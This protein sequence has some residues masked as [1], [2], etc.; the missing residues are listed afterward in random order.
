MLYRAMYNIVMKI[1]SPENLNLPLPEAAGMSDN[2]AIG[3][4]QAEMELDD[5]RT[6]TGVMHDSYGDAT[7]IGRDWDD[8]ILERR[9]KRKGKK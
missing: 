3:T 8:P 4:E 6:G 5:I 1:R 2:R 9:L 7:V